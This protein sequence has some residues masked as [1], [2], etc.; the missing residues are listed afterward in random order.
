MK[1]LILSLLLLTTFTVNAQFEMKTDKW[2]HV[3]VGGIISTTTFMPIVLLTDDYKLAWRASLMTPALIGFAKEFG[4]AYNG[5]EFSWA[6]YG[7]TLA[8]G[9][10]ASLLQRAIFASIHKNNEII[11]YTELAEDIEYEKFMTMFPLT[12]RQ[13]D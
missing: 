5:G 13:I 2:L 1:K 8:G 9:L 11:I 7:C 3:G 12:K 4:D 6:D 10:L